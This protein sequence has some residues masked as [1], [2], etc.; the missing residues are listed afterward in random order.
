MRV[1]GYSGRVGKQAINLPARRATGR[2]VSLE[3][4]DW[5]TKKPCL[6][7]RPSAV[8]WDFRF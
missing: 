5:S 8:L 1:S 7:E 6:L 4:L 3:A 2:A